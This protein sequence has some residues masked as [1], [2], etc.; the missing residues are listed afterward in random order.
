MSGI[1]ASTTN[2]LW[3]LQ[4]VLGQGATASVYMARNKVA[5][6]TVDDFNLIT[7]CQVVF[8]HQLIHTTAAIT[9]DVS[10]CFLAQRRHQD[11]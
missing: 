8:F 9:S 3:S 6:H 7:H 2:Y 11:V 10:A 4:D 1:T 5:S